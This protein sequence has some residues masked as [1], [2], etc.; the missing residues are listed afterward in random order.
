[1]TSGCLANRFLPGLFDVNPFDVDL[2]KVDIGIIPNPHL[3]SVFLRCLCRQY[4]W[5]RISLGTHITLVHPT[6]F[7]EQE[8]SSAFFKSLS[9]PSARISSFSSLVTM[10][11][12]TIMTA[13]T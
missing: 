2:H 11:W 13:T 3:L 5:Y 10:E 9:I 7:R 12:T 6:M 4:R 1:M 8:R